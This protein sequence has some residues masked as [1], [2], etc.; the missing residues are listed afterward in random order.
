M[1]PVAWLA[2]RPWWFAAALL[3]FAALALF[4]FFSH[5]PWR[6][7]GQAWL[8]AKELSR[9][10]DYFIVPGEG[11][12][13]L[14]FWLLKVLSL[15]MP[16]E[17]ARY[18]N[19]G[20]TL[21]NALLLWRLLS[22]RF[23]LFVVVLFSAYF[24]FY[25]GMTFRPYTLLMTLVLVAALLVRSARSLEAGWVLAIAVGLHFYASFIFGLW[26]LVELARRKPILPL[27]GP[28]LLAGISALLAILSGRGNSHIELQLNNLPLG[29]IRNFVGGFGLDV[30]YAF[31]PLAAAAILALLFI[32]FRENRLAFWSLAFC[33][34]AFSLFT[35][36]VYG[37]TPWHFAALPVML[38]VAWALADK[39]TSGV[40]LAV[41]ML[42]W[43]LPTI[44]IAQ[45]SL[46]MPFSGA[47]ATYEALVQVSVADG[48]PLGPETVIVWPDFVFSAP[49]AAHDLRVTSGSTGAEIGPTNWAARGDRDIS[50]QTFARD[51]AYYLICVSC[52]RLEPTIEASGM[53][54]TLI[55]EPVE[56]V[57]ERLSLYRVTPSNS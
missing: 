11:H 28:S 2:P 17:A 46:A 27:V 34:S 26:L 52:E 21:I 30:P 41:L 33:A 54:A 1:K 7:E 20:L 9:P 19:L 3:A 45:R 8:W 22:G 39:P 23:W 51:H 24:V 48:I 38:L 10:T 57:D 16:F 56:A 6:D 53:A 15:V 44:G 32:E 50:A 49:M 43:V 42:P 40:R 36:L 29:P 14:W 13:P 12:P 4:L 37:V 18:L 55:A 35:W 31:A 5:E 25:W 47:W